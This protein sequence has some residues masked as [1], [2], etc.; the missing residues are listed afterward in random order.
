MRRDKGDTDIEVN[1]AY[2]STV[3]CAVG[4]LYGQE[5]LEI[6]AIVEMNDAQTKCRFQYKR[7]TET[8]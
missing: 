5:V 7:I 2:P 4:I 8:V 1:Q 3:E 6:E